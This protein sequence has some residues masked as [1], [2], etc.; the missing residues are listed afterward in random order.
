MLK[1]F[2]IHVCVDLIVHR[3]YF[4]DFGLH[5]CVFIQVDVKSIFHINTL[6]AA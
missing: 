2:K 1:L 6:V 5:V 3:I 4:L